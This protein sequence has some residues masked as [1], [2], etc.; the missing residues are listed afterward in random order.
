MDIRYIYLIFVKKVPLT[1]QGTV[2]GSCTEWDQ[3]TRNS[4]QHIRGC[5]MTH[6]EATLCTEVP[7]KPQPAGDESGVLAAEDGVVVQPLQVQLGREGGRGQGE[8]GLSSQ[9][10]ARP[11]S[12][13]VEDA[14]PAEAG[15]P[16][17]EGLAAVDGPQADRVKGVEAGGCCQGHG[18]AEHLGA[19][20][21]LGA[22]Q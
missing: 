10:V 3:I 1:I 6:S 7:S 19:G 13:G 11:D 5:Q 17:S 22:G 20:D 16:V 15:V 4:Y 12:G 2:K 9:T 21:N 14:A 8:A 18:A